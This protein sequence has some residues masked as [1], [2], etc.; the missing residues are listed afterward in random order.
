MDRRFMSGTF[1]SS[2]RLMARSWHDDAAVLSL[3]YSP[4]A[5][6]FLLHFAHNG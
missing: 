2:N 3:G 5:I 4:F 1:D 6:L